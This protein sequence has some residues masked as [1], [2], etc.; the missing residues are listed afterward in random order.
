MRV[1]V[2]ATD[3]FSKGG[4]QDR[5]LIKALKGLHGSKNNLCVSLNLPNSSGCLI[6]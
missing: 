3:I 5:N 1:L 6:K 2:L 4:I